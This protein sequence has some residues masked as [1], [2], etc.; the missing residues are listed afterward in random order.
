MKRFIALL[1]VAMMCL[2]FVACDESGNTET[3]S[4]ENTENNGGS[5]NDN[6][7]NEND[8]AN[9][10]THT[11]TFGEW[12]VTREAT[13]SRE[14]EETRSCSCGETEKRT[15]AKTFSSGFS[16]EVNADGTS[17]TIT[18]I[19]TCTDIRINMPETI[20]GYTVTKIGNNAFYDC[21]SIRKIIL[22]DT[23]TE[24]GSTAFYACTGIDE[25]IL[26]E[27][28]ET[29]GATAFGICISLTEIRI[30][31]NVKTMADSA[32]IFC[33]S[34]VEV[35]NDSELK[36]VLGDENN[37]LG[38]YAKNLYTSKEPASKLVNVD[39]YVFY[40]DNGKYL[41][42]GYR[43]ENDYLV[44]PKTVNGQPYA[45]ADNSF[46]YIKWLKGMV[47]PEGVTEIGFAVFF[48]CVGIETITIP[49]SVTTIGENALAG[50]ESLTDI[51]YAGSESEW[52]NIGYP[53]AY[54]ELEGKN[55]H[56][57]HAD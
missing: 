53:N 2:A 5:T 1:L 17:C 47:I 8:S 12:S 9:N 43:G 3:P 57:N 52:Q 10:T 14:G 11:H 16:Y 32:F 38:Y 35:C 18:G 22:P 42:V 56:Y 44:L 50:C 21:K 6:T 45:I 36:I 20:D 27:G 54:N 15:I 48:E 28:L 24:I 29:I 39:G 55:I 4:G 33:A 51:Y 49:K 41:L 37:A 7:T 34:L 26:P 25:I 19:G 13:T 46:S 40:N 31:E 30:P 23:I